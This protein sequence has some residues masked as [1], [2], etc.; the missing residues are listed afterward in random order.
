[1]NEKKLLE[2]RHA[3]DDLTVLANGLNGVA[4]V[5]W[6]SMANGGFEVERR[7]VHEHA[8]WVIQRL[9][10]ELS[11]KLDDEVRKLYEASKNA[12]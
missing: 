9:A 12:E 8:A 6:D 2:A 11:T 7:G 5:Y 3:L 10:E 4:F 1:M